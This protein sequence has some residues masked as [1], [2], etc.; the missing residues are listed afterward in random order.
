MIGRKRVVG[1]TQGH[2]G[3]AHLMTVLMFM[4]ACGSGSRGR[5]AGIIGDD[6]RSQNVGDF[7]RHATGLVEIPGGPSC[8]GFLIARDRVLTTVH[9]VDTAFEK[10][11][12]ARFI[13]HAGKQSGITSVAFIDESKDMVALVTS[14][15]FERHYETSVEALSLTSSKVDVRVVGSEGPTQPVTTS[16]GKASINPAHGLLQHDAD[17]VRGMSGSV[18]AIGSTAVGIHIGT[19]KDG[20]VNYAMPLARE[21]RQSARLEQVDISYEGW[22]K[23]KLP[24]IELPKLPDLSDFDPGPAIHK[25]LLKAANSLA[26]AAR[27]NKVSSNFENCVP[28]VAAGVA[29][30]AAAEGA[31]GGPWGAAAGAALGAGGGVHFAQIACRAAFP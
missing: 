24:K 11:S 3:V 6:D 8:N 12:D 22:G 14:I 9:C 20:T 18:V 17:T 10:I 16:A 29:A 15:S 25:A 21:L 19:S 1:W 5:L 7:D 27:D 31:K 4:T 2:W 26:M 13:T 23:W 30:Y 28:M